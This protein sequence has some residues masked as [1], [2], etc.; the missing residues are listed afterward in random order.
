MTATQSE[1]LISTDSHVTEPIELYAERMNASFRDR[2]PRITNTDGWRTLYVEGLRP[3]KLMTESELDMA[4]VGGADPE[5]RLREQSQD[6]VSGEVIFP[7]FA[8]QACFASDDAGLQLALCRSY[9]DW[10]M[11]SLGGHHRMLPVGLVP[12]IDLD[13]AIAE[14]T[15]VARLGFRA[16]FL[17]AR[18]PSRPY[19]DPDYDRFWA[20]AEDLGLPL[21]FHSGTGYEP[22]ITRGPG[23]EVI[24]YIL[25]SQVDG[26]SVILAMAAGGALD[27]FPSLR[28]VTVET[29]ASWLAW[30]MTQADLIHEAHSMFT[31]HRLTMK[32]SELIARQAHATFMNDP[33]AINNR[34]VTGI[35][36]IMW[37]ND[38]PHPEGTWPHSA[39][40]LDEQFK[41]VPEAEKTAM[42]CGTAARV[43]G[44][45]VARLQPS[46]R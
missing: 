33:V 26:P 41:D 22:R 4:V 28:I 24:N 43:F 30:I 11:E 18:V 14:A 3:R 16:L 29:G 6:G 17:P 44:F 36:T 9:N 21:T 5:Q 19:N 12:M 40:A 25:G 31:K 20:V 34:Y 46:S 10:A 39:A 38:Y 35:E 42:V 2:A 37:G 27:R 7:T 15:R 23:A 32:P 13:D 45:D 8:L 1:I